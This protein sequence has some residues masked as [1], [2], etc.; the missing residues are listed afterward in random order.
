[1][2]SVFNQRKRAAAIRPAVTNTIEALE[3]RTLLSV[4][5]QGYV[6]NDLNGDGI[7]QD[8]EAFLAGRTVFVDLNH[9]GHREDGE[10]QTVSGDGGKFHFSL[11]PGTYQIR[12]VL[13][14]GWAQTIPADNAP[15]TITVKADA[16][17]DTVVFGSRD[18]H[19]VI[20][21]TVFRDLNGD[22]V[23]QDGEPGIAGVNV[24]LDLNHDGKHEDGEPIQST[25]AAGMVTFAHLVPGTYSVDV[26]PP[27]H[28]QFTPPGGAV[29]Q[30]TVHTGGTES[31]LFGIDGRVAITGNVFN[32]INDD[33]H[34]QNNEPG[35]SGWTVYLD[36]N[37]DEK[38]EDGEPTATTD[39]H[40]A[41]S[42]T[43]LAPGAYQVRLIGKDG[44][45]QTAP[46]HGFAQ[47]VHVEAGQTLPDVNFG[48]FHVPTTGTLFGRVF[49]DANGNGTRDAGEAGL[50]GWQV[51]IDTNNDQKHEDGEPILTTGAGGEYTFSN[52]PA[53][54]YNVRVILKS[55]WQQTL[56]A[57][58][59]AQ[60]ISVTA[61]H[62]SDGGIFGVR[63]IPAPSA[64]VEGMVFNDLNGDGHHEDGEPGLAGWQVYVDLNGDGKREDGEAIATTDSSGH[65]RL[66]HLPAGSY[67]LRLIAQAG[68]RQTAPANGAGQP[69]TLIAGQSVNGENFGVAHS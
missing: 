47:S 33:G 2:N 40:G 55:G 8:G 51:F 57:H 27:A 35:L 6:F 59:A 3:L 38:R 54:T 44:W 22:G 4:T 14:D 52:L 48:V 53:G 24:F 1:M 68:W 39:A 41:Y 12:Q 26:V 62:T 69:V 65:Y 13:P 36:L 25:S 49:N 20:T 28:A 42:L 60:V 45:T 7:R 5:V 29:R 15:R 17:P 18:T 34:R 11:D 63:E 32:D 19:G 56:P 10:P 37:H 67:T 30:A 64:V 58:G 61:G 46:A 50:P 9:D 31:V 16:T 66:A 21:A 23:R 43:H